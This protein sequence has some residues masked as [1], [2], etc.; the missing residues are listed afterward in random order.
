MA[1]TNAMVDYPYLTYNDLFETQTIYKTIYGKTND[2][3]Q[4]L[5]DCKME[6]MLN[7]DVTGYRTE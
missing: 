1:G 6:W 2:V 4:Y 5:M 7:N 3:I